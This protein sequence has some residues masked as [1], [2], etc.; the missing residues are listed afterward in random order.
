MSPVRRGWPEPSCKAQWK[1]KENKSGRGRGG[2]TTS[3]NGQAWSSPSPI[4]QWSTG[5]DGGNWLWNHLWC[6]NDLRGLRVDDDDEMMRK[7]YFE[8]VLLLFYFRNVSKLVSWCFAP[9]KTQTIILGLENEL[10]SISPLRIS[11]VILNKCLILKPQLKPR[12]KQYHVSE[13]IYM[14][15]ALNTGTCFNCL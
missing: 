14:P 1:E 7:N 5:K 4:G 8:E 15:R 10:Q 3:G 13:P 2:K 12:K 11:Q 6:S 9:R